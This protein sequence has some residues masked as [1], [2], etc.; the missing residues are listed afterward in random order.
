M[1]VPAVELD[2]VVIVVYCNVPVVV[3]PVTPSDVKVPT[4]V[5]LG[6]AAV[7]T[8]PETSAFAT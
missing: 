5:M 8:V 1:I 3:V 7:Y 4:E 2:P 6:C